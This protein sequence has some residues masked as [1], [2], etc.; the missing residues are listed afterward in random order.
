MIAK[1]KKMYLHYAEIV[2]YLI[3]GGLTTFIGLISY[4]IFVNTFLNPK[5]PF[6]LQVANV[7]SWF[8][9]VVFAYFTNRIFVFKS[10][11]KNKL[12]EAFKFL[13]SRVSTLLIEMF[14]MFCLVSILSVDDKIS[15]II[16]QI[17]VFITN[18]LFSKFLV[19][20]KRGD[21]NEK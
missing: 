1:I 17:I 18:Y 5:N 4:F 7:L 15:K 9:A 21:K 16:A 10:E 20:K 3:I 2:N 13:M 12:L 19:F 11:N 8:L 6:E 14:T